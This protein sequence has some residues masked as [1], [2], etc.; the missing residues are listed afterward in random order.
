MKVLLLIYFKLLDGL[1]Y[2][3]LLDFHFEIAYILVLKIYLNDQALF[4]LLLN[5]LH[6]VKGVLQMNVLKHVV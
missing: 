1:F 2:K 4:E 6:F 5:L 3:Y